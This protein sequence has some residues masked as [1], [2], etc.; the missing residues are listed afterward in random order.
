MPRSVAHVSDQLQKQIR[1]IRRG[2][3]H[4]CGMLAVVEA[5]TAGQ[6]GSKAARRILV[7]PAGVFSISEIT[8]TQREINET[9]YESRNIEGES[10][11]KKLKI[12]KNIK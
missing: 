5:K 8:S 4:K 6:T 10:G 1:S 3:G 2:L 11:R 12:I 7:I 9:L